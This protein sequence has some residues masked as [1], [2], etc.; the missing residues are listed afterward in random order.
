MKKDL[1]LVILTSDTL[2]QHIEASLYLLR[3]LTLQLNNGPAIKADPTVHVID[4]TLL[5]VDGSANIVLDVAVIVTYPTAAQSEERGHKRR[6]DEGPSKVRD[7]P[8]VQQQ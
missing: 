4:L 8:V 5:F 1:D 6:E 7:E 2:F 3:L